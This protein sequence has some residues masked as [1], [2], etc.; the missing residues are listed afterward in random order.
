MTK[1]R[2]PLSV[3]DALGRI[4]GKLPGGIAEMTTIVSR[5][6]SQVYAWANPDTEDDIPMGCA[7]ALDIA[8]QAAGGL[9]APIHE[10]YTAKLE[11]AGHNRFADQLALSR[12]VVDVLREC[13]DAEI[14]LMLAA[15]PG[16]NDKDRLKAAREV[17]EAIGVLS[18][19]LPMLG[20]IH[21][22]TDP[23]AGG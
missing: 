2:P 20:G 3:G 18:R 23:P 21:H 5:S 17:Q 8:Y 19:T 22:Q 4:Q 15:Q 11:I 7:I 10:A 1:H 6:K 9:G 12:H 13:S 14:A 16:S